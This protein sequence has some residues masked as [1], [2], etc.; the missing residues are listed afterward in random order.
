MKYFIPA[1]ALLTVTG[2]SL[3]Q[4]KPA[5]APAPV[6]QPS[7]PSVVDEQNRLAN[8]GFYHGQIDGVAGPATQRALHD[9]A[10]KNNVQRNDDVK[11]NNANHDADVQRNNAN[12]D[13]DVKQNDQDNK[14]P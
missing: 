2:C 12:H 13:A 10:N 5:P 11:R 9:E 14:T 1:L 4:S 3:F 6:V 7:D 8:E